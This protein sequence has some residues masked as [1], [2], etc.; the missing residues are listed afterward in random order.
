MR[1]LLTWIIVKVTKISNSVKSSDYFGHTR[2]SIF[3][4][5]CYLRDPENKM[6]CE[7][8]TTTS[9]LSDHSR[10]A[11]ITSVLTVIDHLREKHQHLPLKI[12]SIVWSDGCSTQFRSQFIFKLL[13][14]IESL[15][16]IAWCYNERHHGKGPIDGI[17]VWEMRN[18]HTKTIC[19]TSRQAVKGI[20]SLYIPAKGLLIEP[21]NIE[22]PR[23]LKI[24][25]KFPWLNGFL[26]STTFLTYGSLLTF[27]HKIL[28][29]GACGHQEIAAD[30]NHCGS[31]LGDYEP[32]EEWLQYPR[33]KV[34]FHS[35][36][37]FD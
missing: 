25:F 9:E 15:L 5:C 18:W 31:C 11:A 16:N 36:C 4:A 34:W 2:F 14:S 33:C 37:F 26:M 30:C 1:F 28:C 3:T 19:G 29:E 7:S 32:T 8:V 13:S 24:L 22:A 10:A 27:F 35:N 6:I 23:E 17:R 21:D 20:T 12:N